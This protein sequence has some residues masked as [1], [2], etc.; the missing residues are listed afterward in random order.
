[1]KG[2]R[3]EREPGQQGE[4]RSALPMSLAGFNNGQHPLKNYSQ[5]ETQYVRL[6]SWGLA[7]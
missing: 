5:V 3:N 2:F 4:G 1:M 7:Q 6:Y